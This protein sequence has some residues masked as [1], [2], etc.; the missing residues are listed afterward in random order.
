[1]FNQ[2]NN[3]HSHNPSWAETKFILVNSLADSLVLNLWDYNDHRKDTLL[4]SSTFELSTLQED[5]VQEGVLSQVLK[6]GKERGELRYDVSFYPVLKPEEGEEKM[7][8]SCGFIRC[9]SQSY[10]Y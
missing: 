9:P 4:G 7:P 10:E 2:P 1:M 3:N 8:E 5:A 6:D